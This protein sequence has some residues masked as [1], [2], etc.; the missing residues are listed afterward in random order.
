MRGTTLGVIHAVVLKIISIHV[1]REGH[2]AFTACVMVKSDD[3]SIHV[4]REGHD[5]AGVITARSIDYFYPR[6]P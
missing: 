2:D 4:P 1:P 5:M 6:A 3:I